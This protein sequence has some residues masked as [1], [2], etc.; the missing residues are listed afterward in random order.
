[1]SDSNLLTI[2]CVTFDAGGTLITPY[3]SVGSIYSEVLANHGLTADPVVLERLFKERFLEMRNAQKLVSEESEKEFWRKLVFSVLELYFGQGY[4]EVIFEEM[5]QTFAQ[6]E[7]WKLMPGAVF[8]VN[9]LHSQNIRTAV[10]SN[11]DSRFHQVLDGL[12]IGNLMEKI[13]ISS[14]IGKEK[15]DPAVF[16]H[17]ESVL[18][19]ESH[20]L[21]HIGDSL[22]HDVYGA[23]NAGWKSVLFSN[24]NSDRFQTISDLR[25]LPDLLTPLPF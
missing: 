17:V 16:R 10:L 24:D 6:P 25:S 4:Y 2:R 20:Q 14:E 9:R 13:F 8:A 15:P 23:S 19:L 22:L 21:L 1:M 18:S 3:P 7:R 12:G 11:A 5:F